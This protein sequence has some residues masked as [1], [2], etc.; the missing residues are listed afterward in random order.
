MFSALYAKPSCIIDSNKNRYFLSESAAYSQ[1]KWKTKYHMDGHEQVR[2]VLGDLEIFLKIFTY[3]EDSYLPDVG[4]L[5]SLRFYWNEA[6]RFV[7]NGIH[8][9]ILIGIWA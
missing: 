7:V 4:L 5:C 2:D 8:E 6:E 3:K 1:A 9:G